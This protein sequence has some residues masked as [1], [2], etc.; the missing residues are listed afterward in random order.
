MSARQSR[1]ITLSGLICVLLLG[2]L[3]TSPLWA[4]FLSGQKA[5]LVL[6]QPDFASNSMVDNQKRI[7]MPNDIAIDPVSKKVFVTDISYRR[8]L[9]FGSI[10][11]LTNGASAEAVLGQ[12]DFNTSNANTTPNGMISPTALAFSSNGALWV[13][14]YINNRV[15]RFDNAATKPN[16][17]SADGVLGQA[18][19]FTATSDTA[20]NR[21]SYPIAL[22]IDSN[23][24]LWVADQGNHRVLRF[25]NPTSKENG[26]NADGVLGQMNFTTKTS[27]TTRNTFELPSGVAVDSK[28]TLWVADNG[29]ARVLRFDAAASKP[30]GADADGVLGQPNFTSDTPKT[31][32]NGMLDP[33]RIAVDSSGRLWVADSKNHRVL[34]FENAATKPNG[35]NA[36][37]VLG[38]SNFTSTTENL[39]QTGFNGPWGLAVDQS[40]ALWVADSLNKRVLR[41]KSLIAQTI[42]FLPL[43]NRH[44]GDGPFMVAANA[45]SGLPVTFSSATPTVCTVSGNTVTLKAIGTCTI[46]ASQAG[47]NLTYLAAPN[48]QQSF[49]V[50]PPN[51]LLPFVVR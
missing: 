39:S 21:M 14:D 27:G 50:Q 28:G 32:Q 42:S 45:S 25:N 15:L 31:S 17:A 23:G 4:A 38:Q 9:R 35:A 37:G 47:D 43:A 6:G 19:F 20:Q 16:G 29:N 46:T 34:R 22:T 26:A 1:I 51:V 8:V 36:D 13:A 30:N 33:L 49:I 5:A 41:F 24:T 44:Y 10:D 40:G 11:S 7:D 18:G 3:W 12:P 2:N 48:V